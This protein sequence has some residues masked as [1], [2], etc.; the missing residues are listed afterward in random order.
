[1]RRPW[2]AGPIM[3]AVVCAM[4]LDYTALYRAVGRSPRLAACAEAGGL[5]EVVGLVGPLPGECAVL[6]RGPAEVAVAG[7]GL[8]D[9]PEQVQ[10]LDDPAGGER[11]VLL[12]ELGDVVLVHQGRALG[13]DG[14]ADRVGHADRVGE[15]HLG[16]LGEPRGDDV[17]GDVPGHVA[18]AAVDLG[19]VL[20]AERPAAVRAA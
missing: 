15:L 2:S 7:G 5:G 9:G 6:L 20:A 16:T 18:G 4:R 19:G 8:V 12:D 14:D 11:E 17:L 10:V 3:V 1:M 13:A